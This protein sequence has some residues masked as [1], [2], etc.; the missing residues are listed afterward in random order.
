MELFSNPA[1]PVDIESDSISDSGL[2][3]MLTAT[4]E[5]TDP[6]D[7]KAVRE[8]VHGYQCKFGRDPDPHAPDARI[9]AQLL[10]VASPAQIRAVIYELMAERKEPGHSYA[11]YVTVMLQR[12][13]GIKYQAVKAAREAWKVHKGRPTA[14]LDTAALIGDLAKRK[15]L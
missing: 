11:W 12:I 9:L 7:L 2:D 10:A 5:K 1:P 4:P 14:S 3:R 8:W 15:A 6:E 13:H